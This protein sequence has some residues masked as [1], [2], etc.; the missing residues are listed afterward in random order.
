MSAALAAALY[1]GLEMTQIMKRAKPE[2]S[3]VGVSVVEAVDGPGLRLVGVD[4]SDASPV[5]LLEDLKTGKTYFVRVNEK[6]KDARVKQIQKNKV[7]VSYH[8]KNVELR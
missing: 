3:P 2:T 8:G 5:A 1:F 6:V 7:V 4:S